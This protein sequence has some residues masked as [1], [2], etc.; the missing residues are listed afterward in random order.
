MPHALSGFAFG[1]SFYF[2]LSLHE[3]SVTSTDARVRPRSLLAPSC[4]ASTRARRGP[5]RRLK[6]AAPAQRDRTSSSRVESRDESSSGYCTA[7]VT[8][9]TS[10]RPSIALRSAR[11]PHASRARV[12]YIIRPVHFI[13]DRFAGVVLSALRPVLHSSA[14]GRCCPV[15]SRFLPAALVATFDCSTLHL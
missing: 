3:Q 7:A 11:A 6:W 14:Q 9:V 1:I 13:G 4:A 15:P 5:S 8:C 2:L 12:A 10:S